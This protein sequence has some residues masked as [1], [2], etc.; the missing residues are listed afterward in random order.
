MSSF[1]PHIVSVEDANLAVIFSDLDEKIKLLRKK[2]ES[3]RNYGQTDKKPHKTSQKCHWVC[4]NQKSHAAKVRCLQQ[5]TH[6]IVHVEQI[7][8]MSK[9]FP[10]DVQRLRNDPELRQTFERY[11]RA[12]QSIKHTLHEALD[13]SDIYAMPIATIAL[14]EFSWSQAMD[15][16]KNPE[17]E[18]QLKLLVK[19][20]N[21]RS[22]DYPSEARE[23]LL[24]K[25]ERHDSNN[26][27]AN[28]IANSK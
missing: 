18:P 17:F 12:P 25:I 3:H 16:A 1:S 10:T 2:V 20:W 22:Q 9:D 6:P 27:I 23:E 11:Q 5:C 14:P 8:N 24:R 4:D 28:T 7:E 15:V 19:N 13:I 21:D 26:V